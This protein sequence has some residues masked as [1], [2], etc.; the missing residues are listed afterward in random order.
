MGRLRY[1]QTVPGGRP[2]Y[3]PPISMIV[4][5]SSAL[6]LAALALPATAQVGLGAGVAVGSGGPDG[7]APE[8]FVAA[9]GGAVVAAGPLVLAADV[10][11][12][13][14]SRSTDGPYVFDTEA[15]D[16]LDPYETPCRSLDSGA[17]VPRSLCEQ[18]RGVAALSADAS[19]LVPGVR[20]LSVGAGYRVGFQPTPY[21]VAGYAV[22]GD[23]TR[24]VRVEGVVSQRVAGLGLSVLFGL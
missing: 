8:S 22:G 12:G 17:A 21:A 2:L 15:Y 10:E 24:G 20:G 5:L 6:L 11:L 7:G 19:V 3:P 23:P 13:L 9:T 1:V 18:T 4:R 14:A 16:S